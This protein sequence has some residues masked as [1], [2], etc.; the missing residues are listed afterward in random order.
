MT[1]TGMYR[2]AGN[3]LYTS[4]IEMPFGAASVKA[5]PVIRCCRSVVAFGAAAARTPELLDSF[6]ALA[7]GRRR[8]AP[9]ADVV[10]QFRD[11]DGGSGP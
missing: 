3:H 1:R 4:A 11:V 6:G 8:R 7:N 2:S 10:Q 5:S 9:T